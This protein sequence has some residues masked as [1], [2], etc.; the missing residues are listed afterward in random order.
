MFSSSEQPRMSERSSTS[1]SS[2]VRRSSPTG[3][4]ASS[5]SI[6]A[7]ATPNRQQ[8]SDGEKLKKCILEL[9]DTERT[10][11]KHLNNLLEN[12]LEPL[13][14]ET[15]LSSAELSALFGNIQEIVAFQRL[16]QQS[17]E[18][19][20]AIEVNFDQLDQPHQFKVNSLFSFKGE[21]EGSFA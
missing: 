21:K 19:A 8:L 9:V 7:S 1:T 20:L 4:I 12:Y 13:K 15:F 11:V 6:A 3:S 10:Y 18:E 2:D 17:L 14:R 5:Q 16:F